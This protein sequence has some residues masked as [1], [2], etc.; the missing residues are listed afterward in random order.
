MNAPW[1][2]LHPAAAIGA[3]EVEVA[4]F[5]DITAMADDAAGALDRERQ[6]PMYNR[7]EWLQLTAKHL[8]QDKRL[9]CLRARSG[10]DSAWLSLIDDGNGR[11]RA[12]GGWYTLEIAPAF[13][14][15]VCG[16]QRL[17]LMTGAAHA[18]RRRFN[19]V[20]LRPVTPTTADLIRAAFSDAGWWA[21]ET[22]TTANWITRT[23]GLGFDDY[24][25]ARPSQVK[26]TV[27]RKLKDSGL[28][29]RV[30][31]GFDAA[32]WADYE[33]V[34]AQSWKPAEGSPAFLREAAR[35]EGEAGCLRLGLAYRDGHPVAGQF[36]TV[37]RG[38]AT[39]HKL[40][41]IE[42]ERAASPGTLLSHRMFRHVLDQD[43]PALID[44]GN[45]DEPY[46]AQWMTE[47]RVLRHVTLHNRHHPAGV[48]GATRQTVA[49]WVRGP[50]H[51]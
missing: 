28:E 42:A 17:K 27:R 32:A 46:K 50:G 2:F 22:E 25:R 5:D 30:L 49:A 44:Y 23:Q 37:E 13:S 45:G 1:P 14:G 38:V 9:I 48:A 6:W 20:D 15:A 39:I 40:A 26:N 36:W 51:G 31:T 34:Y 3:P 29:M 24:W 19:R 41:Y 21:F 7:R 10:T 16:A 33:S 4:L 35:I 47:R 18:L 11:A 43:R 8:L 12:A